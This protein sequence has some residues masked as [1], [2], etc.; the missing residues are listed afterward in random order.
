MLYCDEIIGSLYFKNLLNNCTDFEN[1]FKDLLSDLYKYTNVVSKDPKSIKYVNPGVVSLFLEKMNNKYH[2]NEEKLLNLAN[3]RDVNLCYVK[4]DEEGTKMLALKEIMSNDAN[5]NRLREKYITCQKS[6][7]YFYLIFSNNDYILN[8]NFLF[9]RVNPEYSIDE[10]Y[11][12]Y[13]F[14]TNGKLIR[15]SKV[16]KLNN[17]LCEQTYDY[18]ENVILERTYKISRKDLGNNEYYNSRNFDIRDYSNDEKEDFFFNKEL[19][20]EVKIEQDVVCMNND[21]KL[22]RSI[23]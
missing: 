10:L 12:C 13:E 18:N 7:N 22:Q 3:T 17:Y 21:K 16:D 2:L 15:C 5:S 20:K 4:L 1:F 9:E 14:D 19:L 23:K 11:I 8:N 6:N